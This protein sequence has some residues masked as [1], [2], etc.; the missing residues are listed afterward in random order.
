MCECVHKHPSPTHAP[1]VAILCEDCLH[2]LQS[3]HLHLYR[4]ACPSR[5]RHDVTCAICRMSPQELQADYPLICASHES[6]VS[7][8]SCILCLKGPLC[9][10]CYCDRQQTSR[11]DPLPGGKAL[12]IFQMSVF[13]SSL[14]LGLPASVIPLLSL[15]NI[16][17]INC[18]MFFVSSL[19]C[20]SLS[21]SL[22]PSLPPSLYLSLYL[23]SLSIY[24]SIYL[25]VYRYI[26][27]YRP[28]AQSFRLAMSC[29]SLGALYLFRTE[30]FIGAM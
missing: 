29:S 8:A 10:L 6:R 16:S 17:L 19:L 15:S 22:P 7:C 21:L 4:A 24:L 11:L 25:S 18:L 2:S 14:S 9:Y 1:E 12:I 23:F 5:Y 30:S 26:Y 13:S 27:I 20:L 28:C 3:Q